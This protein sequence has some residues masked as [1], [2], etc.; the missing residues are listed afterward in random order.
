VPATLDRIDLRILDLLQTDNRIANAK[1]A[2]AVGLSAPACSRRVAR[3]HDA[4][5]IVKDVAIVDPAVATPAAVILMLAAGT[6]RAK[7]GKTSPR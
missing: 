7:A 3:L 6:R 2:V 5:V 1:L 4:G